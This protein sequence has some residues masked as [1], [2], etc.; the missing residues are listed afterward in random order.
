MAFDMIFA[1]FIL[2]KP[3]N[4]GVFYSCDTLTI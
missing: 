1:N 2:S 3:C 4:K